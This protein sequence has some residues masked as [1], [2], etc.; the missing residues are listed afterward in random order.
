MTTCLS[1]RNVSE[2]YSEGAYGRTMRQSWYYG[3]S[4]LVSKGPSPGPGIWVDGVYFCPATQGSLSLRPR[5]VMGFG[6]AQRLDCHVPLM[7]IA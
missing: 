1:H 4:A 6:N 2:C 5:R 3:V 7:Q